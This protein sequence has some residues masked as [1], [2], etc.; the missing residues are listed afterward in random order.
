MFIPYIIPLMTFYTVNVS[1]VYLEGG[2]FIYF[3]I[4][5]KVSLSA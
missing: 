5:N 3:N 1:V 2:E 4:N